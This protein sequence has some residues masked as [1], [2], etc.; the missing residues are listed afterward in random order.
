[1]S[2]LETFLFPPKYI[3]NKKLITT[4][5]GKTILI[6]GAS[7]GIGE[8]LVYQLS[9]INTCL[10]LVARTEEK[11]VSIQEKLKN[12]ACKIIIFP[13]DLSDNNQVNLLL[14]HLRA[15]PQGIDLF[16][17]NAGKSICRPIMKSLDRYHDFS[18]TI[19]IN[20]LGPVQLTL[21]LI[22]ILSK[23]KGQIINISAINVLL[24]PAPHWAAYQA[25][26]V[27]FDNWFRS[28]SSELRNNNI[29]TSSIYLP[30]VDTRMVKPTK[31]YDKMPK[32]SPKQV[33]TIIC[34][35]V[36]R[37]DRRFVPWWLFMGQIS[38]VIFRYPLEL[39]FS[40]YSNKIKK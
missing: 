32:M 37:K 21:G 25:S 22:P 12:K 2:L 38:S 24:F 27:A 26:K 23:N 33:S 29:T 11:L 3:N 17:N 10:I 8:N 34:Q 31:R 1:M 18:R 6:T 7:Y 36:I 30:L 15:I 40:V 20:Y 4:F 35:S 5:S 28:A 14:S 19:N 39:F 16:V 13:T 9:D